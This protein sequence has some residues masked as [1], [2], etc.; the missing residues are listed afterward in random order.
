M[1]EGLVG[2]DDRD[3]DSVNK[4]DITGDI[5][6]VGLR[7][8]YASYDIGVPIIA[9][10]SEEM[11]VLH[12]LEADDM[13]P[14]ASF[15]LAQLKGMVPKTDEFI[16]QEA[17]KRTQFG[18]YAVHG[19]VMT[20]NSYNEYVANLVRRVATVMSEPIATRRSEA[21]THFPMLQVQ[22]PELARLTDQYIRHG[23][24]GMTFD[25][26]E[27][28]NW[29]VLLVDPVI[30]HV[31]KEVTQKLLR[32]R[33]MEAGG[34]FETFFRRLSEEKVMPMRTSYSIETAK[35]IYARTPFPSHGGGLEE[36]FIRFLDADATV[37]AFGK[38][39]EY[40]HPYI[41]FSYIKEDGMLGHYHPDFLVRC[42]NGK[43]YLVE[44]KADQQVI[45]PN[46]QRKQKA[47]MLWIDKTNA[48]PPDKREN[49]EWAYVLLAESTLY[50][51]QARAGN[52]KDLLEFAKTRK[53]QVDDTLV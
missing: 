32:M 16:S 14:F 48:L 33:D 8:D 23:L 34:G 51:W 28:N 24:F 7:E 37:E 40:K 10:E 12:P 3:L 50:D 45:H 4:E 21:D 39:S 30:K 31:I 49:T 22:M 38:V 6:N 27:D 5:I 29:R 11:F 46:V 52:A 17:T 47:V 1:E 20:A 42:T 35:T 43:T 9:R 2:I 53:T 41:R 25:P 15:T 26:F 13:R 18:D 19:G 44:T 36:K